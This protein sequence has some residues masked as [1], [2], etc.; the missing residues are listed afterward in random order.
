MGLLYYKPVRS[1]FGTRADLRARSAQVEKL[2]NQKTDLE[3][4]LAQMESGDELLRQARRLGLVK[5]GERLFIIKGIE[6][7]RRSQA[8]R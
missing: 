6:A 4:R 2:R 1:Y 7:W 3:R 5:P 8:R